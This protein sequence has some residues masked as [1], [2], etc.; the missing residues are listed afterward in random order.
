MVHLCIKKFAD[1]IKK[2]KGVF[3]MHS[4]MHKGTLWHC[5]KFEY[6]FYL[7]KCI[8]ICRVVVYLKSL[9]KPFYIK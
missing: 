6:I 1:T 3:N 8:E 5:N 2:P 9:L 4:I 7:S